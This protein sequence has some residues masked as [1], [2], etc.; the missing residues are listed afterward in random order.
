VAIYA[1]CPPEM[2]VDHVIPLGGKKKPG[3]TAEGYPI[4]GLHVDY[5][6]KYLPGSDNCRK[7]RRMR[8]EEQ[9]LCEQSYR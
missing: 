8:P 3:L 5:N 6:L 2:H 4:C 1:A 9:T 7:H